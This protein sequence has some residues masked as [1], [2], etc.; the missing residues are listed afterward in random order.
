MMLI[1][2]MTVPDAAL[3]VD[4]LKAHLRLGTGFAEDSVQNGVLSGFLRAAIAAIEGRTNKVLIERAFALVLHEW[5]ATDA[6]VLPVAPVTAITAIE[7]VDPAGQGSALDPTMYWLEEDGQRPRLRVTGAAWPPLPRGGSARVSFTA[8]YGP[9]FT[10][11]PPDLAQAVLLLAAHFYEFRHQTEADVGSMPFGV[12]R[13]IDRYR[14]LRLWG[15]R[16]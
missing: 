10:A 9:D 4:A 13:L 11:L 6:Q 15:E 2:E 7:I 8:G 14:A 5:Q 16:G 3:P 1:E 12:A